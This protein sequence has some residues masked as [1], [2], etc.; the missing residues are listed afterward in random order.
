MC[1]RVQLSCSKYASEWIVLS[2]NDK[3]IRIVE[4]V[5][6]A[7]ADGPFEGKKLELSKMKTVIVL[8]LT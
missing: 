2:V 6:E 4:I 3:S 8:S 7:L 1:C 5:S